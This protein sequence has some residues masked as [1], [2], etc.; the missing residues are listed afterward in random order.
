MPTIRGFAKCKIAIYADDHMPPHFH[1]EGRN[2]R[3][4]VEI[5]TLRVRAGNARH[6]GEALAWA[7]KSGS[8]A[9]GMAS[10]EPPHL[11]MQTDTRIRAVHADTGRRLAVTWKGGI[12]SVV[13]LAPHLARYAIFAPLRAEARGKARGEAAFRG[14]TVGDWGW[15]ARWTDEMEI[16][17]DTFGGSRWSKAAPGCAGGAPRTA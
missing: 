17:A 5:D 9:P 16:A 1:I 12:E 3:A 6:V 4:V 7:R 13:D 14:V 15:C 8:V 2:L 10:P 11:I